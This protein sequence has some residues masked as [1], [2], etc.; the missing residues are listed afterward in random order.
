MKKI[1]GHIP[2]PYE[3]EEET[4]SYNPRR[5]YRHKKP[6]RKKPRRWRKGQP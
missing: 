5:R 6:A 1:S 2:E 3:E 4:E